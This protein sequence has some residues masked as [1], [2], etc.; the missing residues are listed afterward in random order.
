MIEADPEHRV[1]VGG[2]GKLVETTQSPI[3]PTMP[4]SRVYLVQRNQQIEV[5]AK[6]LV[7]GDVLAAVARTN[8]RFV[9]ITGT[10]RADQRRDA[11][12][13]TTTA[14]ST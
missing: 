9:A 7:R 4:G 8:R 2:E 11:S 12:P 13:S 3:P 1:A 14:S 6:S 10:R 5:D